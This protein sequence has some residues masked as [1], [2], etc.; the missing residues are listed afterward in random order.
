MLLLRFASIVSFLT[1]AF[2][3]RVRVQLIESQSVGSFEAQRPELR[4]LSTSR[5]LHHRFAAAYSLGSFKRL[6]EQ[7]ILCYA[8]PVLAAEP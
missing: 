2:R 8:K 6:V 5:N 1:L 3:V 4:M 7:E